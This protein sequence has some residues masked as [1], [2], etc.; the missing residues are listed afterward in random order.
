MEEILAGDSTC[1][2]VFNDQ[3]RAVAGLSLTMAE[4]ACSALLNCR[5]TSANAPS[6]SSDFVRNRILATLACLKASEI[7]AHTMTDITDGERNH[8][9]EPCSATDTEEILWR[10]AFFC[11]SMSINTFERIWASLKDDEA[12]CR[13]SGHLPLISLTCV[14]PETIG[15][16]QNVEEVVDAPWVFPPMYDDLNRDNILLVSADDV[17]L[18]NGKRFLMRFHLKLLLIAMWWENFEDSLFLDIPD[19]Q[20]AMASI[21]AH[22]PKHRFELQPASLSKHRVPNSLAMTLKSRCCGHRNGPSTSMIRRPLLSILPAELWLRLANL[23]P[24]LA[25]GA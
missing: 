1:T 4:L 22:P 3:G 7:I 11:T 9:I 20:H 25:Q 10:R 16:L 13:A 23:V 8:G 2:S 14:T 18:D 24:A 17:L 21:D 12:E 15:M 5:T 6:G 19:F